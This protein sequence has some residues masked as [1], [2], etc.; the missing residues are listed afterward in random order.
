MTFIGYLHSVAPDAERLLKAIKSSKGTSAW[1]D[2]GKTGWG[3]SGK[4]AFMVRDTAHHMTH[5]HDKLRKYYTA[6]DETFVEHHWA[7]EWEH[8]TIHFDEFH[9][10]NGTCLNDSL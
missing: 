4:N 1:D 2:F 9:L 3:S 6:C 5:A 10:F 8:D 7:G